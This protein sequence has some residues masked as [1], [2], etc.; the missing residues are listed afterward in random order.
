MHKILE[1]TN[2]F[3][4][5]E[6]VRINQE[7]ENGNIEKIKRM[8]KKIDQLNDKEAKMLLTKMKNISKKLAVK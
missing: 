3:E 1:A 4:F 8:L 5:A 2:V 6:Y 7:Q